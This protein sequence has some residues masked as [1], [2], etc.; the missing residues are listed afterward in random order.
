MDLEGDLAMIED[1]CMFHR[2]KAAHETVARSHAR[3]GG[4]R[5]KRGDLLEGSSELQKDVPRG[6]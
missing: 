4:F 5:L 2:L 3:D 1:H 6:V